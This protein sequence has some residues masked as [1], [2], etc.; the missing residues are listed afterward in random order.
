MSQQRRG[1]FELHSPPTLSPPHSLSFNGGSL[2]LLFR[3]PW[4]SLAARA[5]SNWRKQGWGL[6]E[7]AGERRGLY[8]R[9]PCS[10]AQPSGPWQHPSLK[11]APW[12]EDLAGP[13]SGHSLWDEG[14]SK[15]A[16]VSLV[17][18]ELSA[19]LC[20][21]NPHTLDHKRSRWERRGVKG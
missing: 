16:P 14:L 9:H 20:F 6:A 2:N 21:S 15:R 12:Q 13:L 3:L 8:R 5:L 18:P 19:C 4:F 7:R 11:W 10:E 17:P 1:G